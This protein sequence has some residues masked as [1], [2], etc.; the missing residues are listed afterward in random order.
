MAVCTTHMYN[1]CT[2]IL[3]LNTTKQS[4]YTHSYSPNTHTH[5]KYL[6]HAYTHNQIYLHKN[7]H[8]HINTK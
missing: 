6:Q 1:S 7:T 8:S 3:S 4:C 2:Y 5:H